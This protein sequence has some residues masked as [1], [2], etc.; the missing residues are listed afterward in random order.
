M[1]LNLHPIPSSLFLY[2]CTTR[3]FTAEVSELSCRGHNFM[4]NLYDDAV[5]RGFIME[6]TRTGNKVTYY[7]ARVVGG[8]EDTDGEVVSWEFLPTHE[9]MAQHRECV[10]T[11]VIIFND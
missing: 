5:D 3:H 8:G 1:K 7:L 9:S 11:K 6:S 10:N 4:W 2:D